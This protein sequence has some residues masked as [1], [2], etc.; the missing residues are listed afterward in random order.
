MLIHFLFPLLVFTTFYVM[1]VLV[2]ESFGFIV[3]FGGL[4]FISCSLQSLQRP[5]SQ[6]V[7]TVTILLLSVLTRVGEKLKD[8]NLVMSIVGEISFL[9]KL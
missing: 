7:I 9:H 1:F 5:N 3:T 6:P 4:L 2:Y 8:R